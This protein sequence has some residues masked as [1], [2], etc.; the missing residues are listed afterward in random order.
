MPQGSSAVRLTNGLYLFFYNILAKSPVIKTE[1]RINKVYI[2]DLPT[3]VVARSKAMVCGRW[4][5]GF[6]S[7]RGHE[8]LSIVSDVCCQVGVSESG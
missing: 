3:P 8:Y 2:C 5:C 4:D 1:E 7:R 6:E